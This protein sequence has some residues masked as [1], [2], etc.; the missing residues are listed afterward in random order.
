MLKRSEVKEDLSRGRRCD[1]CNGTISRR[2]R[3]KAGIFFG[4]FIEERDN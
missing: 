2:M 4:Q 3:A 1:G